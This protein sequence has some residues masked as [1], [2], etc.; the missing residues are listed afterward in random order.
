[1]AKK[2]PQRTQRYR[3]TLTWTV[4]GMQST[5]TRTIWVN[6]G[7]RERE[8][9]EAKE[10]VRYIRSCFGPSAKIERLVRLKNGQP[11]LFEKE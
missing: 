7:P 5:I 4:T 3:Y 9:R 2:Q 10:R 11:D 1:M 6:N 8:D